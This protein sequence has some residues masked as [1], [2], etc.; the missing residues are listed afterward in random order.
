M[1]SVAAFKFCNL[2]HRLLRDG[3]PEFLAHSER[4][5]F[6]LKE[7]EK[8]WMSFVTIGQLDTQGYLLCSVKYCHYIMDKIAF[9]ATF[10]HISGNF[11][12]QNLDMISML[13]KRRKDG[14]GFSR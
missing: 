14:S 13:D 1:N 9:H 7:F 5:L 4:C 11:S 3:S 12:V 6:V 8:D 10:K 2:L